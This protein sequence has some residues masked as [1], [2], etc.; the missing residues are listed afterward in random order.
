[1]FLE[2]ICIPG[3]FQLFISLLGFPHSSV[4]KESAGNAAYT[5]ANPGLGR[6]AAGEG[7]G[8]PLQ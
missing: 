7:V 2:E 4:G 1:M 8:Y 5:G 6:S 3:K